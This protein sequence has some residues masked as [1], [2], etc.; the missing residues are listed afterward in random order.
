MKRAINKIAETI[1]GMALFAGMIICSCEA[2]N[3]ELQIKVA[4]VGF[5]IFLIGFVLMKV[6]ECRGDDYD[7]KATEVIKN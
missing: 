1:G 4:A 5:A 7:G 2:D 6:T 3:W